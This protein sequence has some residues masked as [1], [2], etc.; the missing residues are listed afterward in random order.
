MRSAESVVLALDAARETGDAA[1]LSQPAHAFAATGEN[2]V[3]VG[4]VA[5][6]PY[7]AV[8][9]RVEDVVQGDRELHRAQIGRQMAARPADR[10]EDELA[11]LARELRQL[12]AF[13]AGA[14]QPG[15]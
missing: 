3:G 1:P 2:L 4:L 12:A 6:V 5:H 8:A 14:D 13:P 11:Q 7:Q 10:I 15:R 9:R